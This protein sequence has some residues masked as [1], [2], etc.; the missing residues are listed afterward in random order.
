VVAYSNCNAPCIA[1]DYSWL[2]LKTKAFTLSATPLEGH[3][4]IGLV[5]QC[6]EYAR[7]WW[8]TQ[9][10]V[11]F[12]DVEGASDILFLSVYQEVSTGAERPL[13]RSINGQARR[14]PQ[15]GDLLIYAPDRSRPAWRFGHVAVV[16]EV[17]LTEGYLSL[18]EQN[19]SNAPWEQPKR[20]ARR[21][22]L[23]K[24]GGRYRVIDAPLGRH[25]SEGGEVWGWVS[26]RSS[27]VSE[28]HGAPHSP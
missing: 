9:Q 26:A 17:N 23:F 25:T 14:A 1:S 16:V 11:T 8:M 20:Y 3:H 24:V 28:P 15:R 18:A 7:R 19:L 5:Y 6:V 21:A 4:Y 10:G 27:S 12:G 2:N 13:R 22:Q